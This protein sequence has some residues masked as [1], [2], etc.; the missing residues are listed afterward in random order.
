MEDHSFPREDVLTVP[1]TWHGRLH[2]RRGGHVGAV[3]SRGDQTLDRVWSDA[4]LTDLGRD[5]DPRG[6]LAEPDPVTASE[7]LATSTS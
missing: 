1:A 5:R 3:D 6:T 7:I 4:R 2:P